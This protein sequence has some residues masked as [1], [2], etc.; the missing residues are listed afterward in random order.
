MESLDSL[1]RLGFSKALLKA[2][3]QIP[4]PDQ[5]TYL[6]PVQGLFYATLS[7]VSCPAL[8]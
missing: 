5:I 2:R 4:N 8:F 7:I 3:S 6:T 1:I